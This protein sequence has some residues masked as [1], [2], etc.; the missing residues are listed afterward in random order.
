MV[1][2]ATQVIDKDRR[3][4]RVVEEGLVMT[5]VLHKH[6]HDGL[7]FNIDVYDEALAAGAFLDT[8]IITAT[9]AKETNLIVRSVLGGDGHMHIYEDVTVS[10]NGT[11]ATGFNRNRTS[12][13][14]M[15]ATAFDGPTVTD[16]GT[17]IH[18]EII[19]GGAGGNASGAVSA[20]FQEWVLKPSAKYIIRL[21]NTT[22]QV[23]F[24]NIEAIIYEADPDTTP[25]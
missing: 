18:F 5:E 20:V 4:A 17:E 12:A 8:L 11:A 1:S 13:T 15:V 25:G 21:H 24:A 16:L 14:T 6:I 2:L 7:L 9:A 19:P 22:G 3:V 10:D 23:Q